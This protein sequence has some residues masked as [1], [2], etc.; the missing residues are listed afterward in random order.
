MHAKASW[1]P[2]LNAYGPLLAHIFSSRLFLLLAVE[3][4]Y[5][6]IYMTLDISNKIAKIEGNNCFTYD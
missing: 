3:R 5:S 6:Y 1:L 2:L 4:I